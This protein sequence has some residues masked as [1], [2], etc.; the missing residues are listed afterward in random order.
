MNYKIFM[1]CHKP[2]EFTPP[3]CTA[4]QCGSALNSKLPDVVYDDE[5]CNNISEKNREYCELTAHYYAWKNIDADYYGFCHYRRFFLFDDTIKKPYLAVDALRDKEKK[6]LGNE[7]ELERVFK[8]H[9]I[10]APRSEDMGITV[11]EHYCTSD[12]HYTEDMELFL[13]IIAERVPLLSEAAAAYLAQNRQYF[14][15]MFIMD[16]ACFFE[17]CEILFPVLGEFDRRKTPHGDF[18]SDRTDGYLG[19][20]F[21]GIY[22]NYARKKGARIKELPRLD[23]NCDMKKRV[24]YTMLPPESKLRFTAKRLA[25]TVKRKS[26]ALK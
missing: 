24:L 2:P 16:K 22:I 9:D 18:Q 11:R 13:K 8:D 6:F 15:N 23:I 7:L 3:L 19:E 1:C 20:V 12:H 14:C 21:T 26:S 17:Y 4:I 25:K 5:G 10:I